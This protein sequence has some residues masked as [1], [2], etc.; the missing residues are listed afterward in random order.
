MPDRNGKIFYTSI[1]SLSHISKIIRDKTVIVIAHRLSSIKKADKICVL[2]AG[3]VIAQGTH[4]ELI[5][6]SAEYQKLWQASNAA[7]EWKI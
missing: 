3:T 6:S 7:A 4:E 5:A 2:K 1:T